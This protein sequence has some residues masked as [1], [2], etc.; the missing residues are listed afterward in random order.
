MKE[1]QR[2]RD[3]V[4]SINRPRAARDA[5]A[6]HSHLPGRDEASDLCDEASRKGLTICAGYGIM[7][8]LT[9]ENHMIIFYIAI[10]FSVLLIINFSHGA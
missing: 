10:F 9:K 5:N 3:E 2:E 6:S 7:Y 8:L 1:G 4:K